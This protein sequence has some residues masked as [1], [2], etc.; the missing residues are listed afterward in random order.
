MYCQLYP[1]VLLLKKI[2]RWPTSV[3]KALAKTVNLEAN[4]L[5]DRSSGLT[6]V[7]PSLNSHPPC[8]RDLPLQGPLHLECLSGIQPHQLFSKGNP[9]GWLCIEPPQPEAPVTGPVTKVTSK[10]R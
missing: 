8:A 10:W 7:L 3:W 6:P 9:R 2:D 4:R 1:E 5:G